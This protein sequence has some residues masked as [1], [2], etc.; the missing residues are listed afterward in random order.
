MEEFPAAP[1]PTVLK[2]SSSLTTLLAVAVGYGLLKTMP[3]YG[4]PHRIAVLVVS[5]IPLMLVGSFLFIISGFG[6]EGR[7]LLVRRVLW[8]TRIDLSDLRRM[9]FDPM[10]IKGAVRLLGNGG[11]FSFSGLY[12]TKVLGRFRLFATD[13]GNAVVLVRQSRTVVITPADPQAF[14]ARLRQQFPHVEC[15]PDAGSRSTPDR[16]TR[17]TS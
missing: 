4:V 7:T 3:A 16:R 9:A 1:W 11:L 13:P 2:V 12:R 8:S 17:P 5:T 15:S 10:A 6:L 14:I